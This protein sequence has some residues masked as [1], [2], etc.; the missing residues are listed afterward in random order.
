M[1]ETYSEYLVKA[2]KS[3]MAVVQMV[4]GGLAAAAGLFL[5][6]AGNPLFLLLTIAGGVGA[7]FGWLHAD[8][9]YEAIY[10][11][12]ALEIA[13]V[14][15]KSS[16]KK[17]Y[18]WDMKDVLNYHA[19]RK[20]DAVRL[21]RITRDYSSGEAGAPCVVMKVEKDQKQEVVC[22]EPGEEM[23]GIL[24]MRYRQLEI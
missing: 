2:G 23:L 24:R 1:G 14:Y 8:T 13:A 21:G 22:F 15:R 6:L 16:R 10:V 9:E 7:Y 20:E 11:D 12:G 3:P 17:K 18:E 5:T 4:G 19:G